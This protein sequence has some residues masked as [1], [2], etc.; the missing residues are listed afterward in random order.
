MKNYNFNVEKVTSNCIQWIKEWFEQNGK[1]CKAVIGMSGGKDSTIAAALCAKA[2]G[3][4]NVIGVAMPDK[5]QGINDADKICEHLGIRYMYAPIAGITA[6][7]GHMWTALD[8]KWSEQTEQNIPPRVRMT[9]LYAIAQTLNG[10]VAN[11]CN[12]S[13]DFVG[14]MTLYGDQAGSFSPLGKLTVTEILQIGDYIGL[15]YEMV[16]KTPDDGLPHSSSDEEKFGFTYAEL[17]RFIREGIVPDGNCTNSDE[18]K[19]K[20]I[21]RMHKGAKFKLNMVKVPSFSPGR[22]IFHSIN[23]FITKKD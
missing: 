12:L 21:E 22:W 6:E 19:A 7:F 16:H 8:Y 17:D 1:G 23:Y 3:S 11:T 20:K 13:E 18:P 10:R 9:M 14:Y 5:G 2:L 4:E 15:P